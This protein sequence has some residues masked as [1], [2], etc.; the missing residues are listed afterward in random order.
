MGNLHFSIISFN[1]CSYHLYSFNSNNTCSMH[2]FPINPINSVSNSWI[3]LEF[4]HRMCI[5]YFQCIL[6]DFHRI[7]VHVNELKLKHELNK[8]LTPF[9]KCSIWHKFMQ[10]KI[11]QIYFRCYQIPLNFKLSFVSKTGSIEN[12]I[13]F[14]IVHNSLMSYHNRICR[15]FEYDMKKKFTW[16]MY[17]LLFHL[18][19]L[20][21]AFISR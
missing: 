4:Q 10:S 18:K 13:G 17:V 19:W 8:T 11:K 15:T 5:W 14:W 20:L 3:L 2:R 7:V 16:N 9:R 21:I 6:Y 1:H 12:G